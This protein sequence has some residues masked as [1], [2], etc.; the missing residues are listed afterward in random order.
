MN[1]P[2]A[3]HPI[4]PIIR[5]ASRALVLLFGLWMF[6]NSLD[7]RDIKTILLCIFAD[8]GMTSWATIAKKE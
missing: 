1:F 6:Y 7:P 4:W 2:D 8:A 3:N 5:V